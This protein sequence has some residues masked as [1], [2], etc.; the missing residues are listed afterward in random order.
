MITKRKYHCVDLFAGCGGLSLGLSQAGFQTLAFSEINPDAAETFAANLGGE[1]VVQFGDVTA[2]SDSA[3]RTLAARWKQEKKEV[4]LIAGGPPCQGYSGIGHRRSYRVQRR[5]IPSNHLYLEMIRVIEVLRPKLFLFE[6]VAGLLSGRWTSGGKKGEI[7][8]DI[9]ESF[10]NLK[11][12]EV[13]W[14]VVQSRD[15]GVPQ[16]RPRLLLVGARANL[17]WD[18][19]AG[20]PRDRENNPRGLL[21]EGGKPWPHLVDVLGDLDDLHFAKHKR[22]ER[23]LK[24]PS[25]DFQIEMRTKKSSRKILQRGDPLTEQEYTQHAARTVE[26]FKHMLDFG[27]SIPSNMQTKKFAQRLLPAKWGSD[28]P[29]ITATSLPDDFVHYKRPRILT[30]REWA[31][32]QT[33]PDWFEFRGPRTTGGIRRAGQPMLGN[34]DREVPKYTQIGNA[35]PVRLARAVG[36]HLVSLLRN[37]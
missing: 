28:G 8:D 34:W 27:G 25:S 4:D 19:A 30:V 33:F 29:T 37:L 7:W 26:K 10:G 23:Y 9:R 20:N 31:R 14:K 13:G 16:K 15:F 12:Y 21:P 36:D 17:P 1:D 32:L 3:L 5:E 11:E 18:L 6:N 24:P 35:V 22:N 2:I